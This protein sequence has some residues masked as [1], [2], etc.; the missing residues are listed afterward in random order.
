MWK[1]SLHRV[2]C[3]AG[4]Q[5]RRRRH[6]GS[7]VRGRF[8][9]AAAPLVSIRARTAVPAGGS[10]RRSERGRPSDRRSV[11]QDRAEAGQQD[12]NAA[13]GEYRGSHPVP[14]ASEAVIP[15]PAMRAPIWPEALMMDPP[16]A[17]VPREAATVEGQQG[18]RGTDE[19][20]ESEAVDRDGRREAALRRQEHPEERQAREEPADGVRMAAARGVVCSVRSTPASRAISCAFSILPPLRVR[21]DSQRMTN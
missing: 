21:A 15:T 8:A 18:R 13:P 10:E 20:E 4:C 2:N 19:E 17:R 1:Q 9:V 11:P 7:P 12:R 5:H 14:E 3:S 16:V 6:S